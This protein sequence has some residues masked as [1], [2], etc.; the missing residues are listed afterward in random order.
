MLQPLDATLTPRESYFGW[1]VFLSSYSKHSH[2]WIKI[3]RQTIL[4]DRGWINKQKLIPNYI[5][6]IT[7]WVI[8]FPQSFMS[9]PKLEKALPRSML[10]L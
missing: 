8:I 9:L 1:L 5:R 10:S 2:Q 7:I 3:K 4:T 6:Q